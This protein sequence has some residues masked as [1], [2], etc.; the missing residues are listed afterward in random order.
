MSKNYI[1]IGLI[2]GIVTL[3]YFTWDMKTTSSINEDEL[4]KLNERLLNYEDSLS[5]SGE[6][7]L[8][9]YR[10]VD[11]LVVLSKTHVSQLA[12]KDREIRAGKGRYN[13]L[14]QDS[15]GKLMNERAWKAKEN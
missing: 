1:I 9:L 8:I 11:S 2:I 5:Q 12:Q 6:Q 7:R 3:G 14:K 4:N 10:A 15:L 13:H